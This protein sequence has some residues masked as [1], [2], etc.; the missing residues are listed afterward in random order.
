MT[1]LPRFSLRR[2][3]RLEFVISDSRL[4]Y[5]SQLEKPL[6]ILE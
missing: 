6:G 5:A 4:F 3:F 2:R 1:L